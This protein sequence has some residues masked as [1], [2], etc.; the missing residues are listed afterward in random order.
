MGGIE[1]RLQHRSGGPVIRLY[2][3]SLVNLYRMA[4]FNILSKRTG[5]LKDDRRR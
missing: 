3:L 1:Y 2:K 5:G 4:G